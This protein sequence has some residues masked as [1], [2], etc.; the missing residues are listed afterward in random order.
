MRKPDYAKAKALLAQAGYV[1]GQKIVVLQP[2]D[3]PQYSAAMTVLV[4]SL[5]KAG[6]NVDIQAA[7]WSTISVRRAKKDPPD[8]GGWH[9]FITTHG[10]PDVTTPSTNAWFNSRCEQANPG[11]ACD[12]ELE[13]LVDGWMRELDPAKRHA[14]IE[15]I[16]ARAFESLPYI[17]FG[18]FFQPIAF[19]K[20]VTGVV[21]ASVPVY[22]NIDKR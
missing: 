17:P 16:Q 13:K 19:R 22:W 20:N 7:D 18:Q 12:P 21:E 9:L 8:K 14:R 3:R 6:V 5:R 11:W 10:G 2:T 1:A 4:A 15:Q